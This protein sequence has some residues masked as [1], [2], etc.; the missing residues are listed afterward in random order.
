MGA[1]GVELVSDELDP[2]KSYALVLAPAMGSGPGDLHEIGRV[3]WEVEEFWQAADM[4]APAADDPA[5]AA[6]IDKLR[7]TARLFALMQ[8]ASSDLP[9]F[10]VT[11][12]LVPC[13]D[14]LDRGP[15]ARGHSMQM[16]IP[17]DDL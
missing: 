17:K 2:Q 10:S 16:F 3:A 9:M 4:L 8:M 7:E 11:K 12:A 15:C 14:C 6:M 13:P 5:V 1:R